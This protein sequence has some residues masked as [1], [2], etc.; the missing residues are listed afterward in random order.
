MR[1]KIYTFMNKPKFNVDETTCF[2][3]IKMKA[4]ANRTRAKI[5]DEDDFFDF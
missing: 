3:L 5:R 4:L 2:I 1:L